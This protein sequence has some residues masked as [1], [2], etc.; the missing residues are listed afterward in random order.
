MQKPDAPWEGQPCPVPV[1]TLCNLGH[2][3]S[4]HKPQRCPRRPSQTLHPT[5][6]SPRAPGLLGAAALAEAQTLL[7]QGLTTTARACC[8]HPKCAHHCVSHTP[9]SAQAW[10]RVTLL[11]EGF[12]CSLY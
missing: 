8:E 9:T 7:G 10:V 4:T 1:C 11:S 6:V 3:P 5:A 2:S 12:S